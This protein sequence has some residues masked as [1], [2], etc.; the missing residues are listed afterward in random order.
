MSSNAMGQGPKKRLTIQ[1]VAREAGVSNATVSIVLSGGERAERRASEQTRKKIHQIA[2]RLGYVPSQAARG[3]RV[4]SP[5]TVALIMRWPESPWAQ[6][7]LRDVSDVAQTRGYS[8]VWVSPEDGLKYLERGSADIAILDSAPEKETDLARL[9]ALA[10]RGLSLCI[11]SNAVSPHGFDVVHTNEVSA[12]EAGVRHLIAAGHRRIACLS[13]RQSHSAGEA[14]E[15]RYLA[16]ARALERS[17]IELDPEL[18]RAVGASR[19]RAFCESRELLS[20]NEPP[21]AIFAVSDLAAIS[22]IWAALSLGKR[23]PEEVSIMGVGN[24]VEGTLISPALTTIGPMERDYRTITRRL[25]K[26]H[27]HRGEDT[28]GVVFEE[29]WEIIERES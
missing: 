5:E 4:G 12:C 28:V 19:E 14:D 16:Y 9:Q 24:A 21:T 23:V 1:D 17:G 27:D 7:I 11:F 18:V 20:L 29:Q 10:A 13:N 8:T 15:E 2:E 3:L 22:A 26:R 6:G 25:F